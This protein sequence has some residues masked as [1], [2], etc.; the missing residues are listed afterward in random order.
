MSLH[1]FT[2]TV[3]MNDLLFIYSDY[4]SMVGLDHK[5]LHEL[6]WFYV[7]IYVQACVCV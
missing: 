7:Q 6:F 3:Q 5:R 1:I 4:E 2:F